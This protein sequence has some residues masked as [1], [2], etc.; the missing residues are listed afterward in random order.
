MGV[1]RFGGSCDPNLFHMSGVS[2]AQGAESTGQCDL[3]RK[4]R[5]LSLLKLEP[6]YSS[7]QG[8]SFPSPSVSSRFSLHP[9]PHQCAHNSSSCHVGA[10]WPCALETASSKG[11]LALQRDRDPLL[12]VFNFLFILSFFFL[13]HTQGIRVLS[14]PTRDWTHAPCTESGES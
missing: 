4:S 3:S 14:S 13:L 7:D 5:A 11:A 6:G 10:R 1:T 12:V 9:E 8:H 2:P